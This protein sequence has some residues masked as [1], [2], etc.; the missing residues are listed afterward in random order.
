MSQD[1]SEQAEFWT[2]SAGQ[3]WVEQQ[4]MLDAFMQPVLDGVMTRA[5]LQAGQDVLDIGCGTGASTLI[6]AHHIGPSGHVLGADISPTMLAHA[7]TRAADHSNVTFTQAD[8]ALHSFDNGQYDHLISR[9]GVMFFTDPSAAFSN[10]IK[11]L[12]P[13]AH[14]TFA[15]WGDIANNPWFTIAAQ[16]AKAEL[17]APPRVNPDDPGPFAFRDVTRVTDI[18]SRAGFEHIEADVAALHLTPPG[19]LADVA[20]MATSV[21][22]AART[23][24][25]FQ[26]SAANATAIC[27]RVEEA[28]QLFDTDQGIRVPAEINFFRA[29]CPDT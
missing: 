28:F 3:K 8:A 2:T 9:F 7:Q 17:G 21:G 26:G 22:P 20:R 27:E 15:A 11:G 4:E 10:M 12:K 24:A 14:V 29:R 23:V 1:N 18:L 25:H 16:A 5:A 13:G 19:A 6:A